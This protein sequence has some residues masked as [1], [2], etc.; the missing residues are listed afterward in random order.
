MRVYGDS[1]TGNVR[2]NNE[3]C[4][5][6]HSDC[7][8]YFVM[9]ADGMGGAA[10]GELASIITA[11]YIEKYIL[12]KEVSTIS[13]ALI[14]DAIDYANRSILDRAGSDNNLKGMGSTLTFAAVSEKEIALA[15]IGDSAAFLLSDGILNK[16]T[17]DHSYVQ[18]LMDM[19]KI[20]ESEAKIS[21]YR[22]IITRAMGMDDVK[23]DHY[24][25]EWKKGDI[26]LLCSDGMTDN[27]DKVII[28][29]I[30]S[31]NIDIEDKV[32]RLLKYALDCGGKD[33]ISVVIVENIDES[34]GL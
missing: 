21:P 4:I 30:L 2:R 1:I 5:L 11:Q 31:E 8:P 12:E 17:V 13:N 28:K 26:L 23:A 18:Y 19:G 9:V 16:I 29:E 15:Q 7:D 20:T 6:I 25:L 10:A 33:N 32:D 27:T 34:E 22:N 24:T 14:D 3:D